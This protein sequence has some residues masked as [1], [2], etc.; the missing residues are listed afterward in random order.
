[1]HKIII[2]LPILFI[3]QFVFGQSQIGHTTITFQDSERG[4]RNIE[5]EIY[6]PAQTA[7]TDTQVEAGQFPV[8]VFGHG[9][10]MSWDAYQNLW[11][12][13]VPRGYIMVFPRTEGS[14]I[15]TDHQ[16][17][18]WDLEFLV[19]QMQVEGAN[20]GSV[21]F[22]AVASETALMGHSM[23]GGAAFLAADSLS[24]NGNQNLKTLIGLAPAES[25]TN[26]VSSINSA[27]SVT[28][29]SIILSGGQD[30]VTPPVDHHIPMYNSLASDC[31]TFINILGGAHCYF[32]NS[33][34][35]CDFGEGTSSTGISITR[36]DQHAVTFDFVNL[37]LDYALKNSCS[38][39]SSFTSLLAMDARITNQQSCSLPSVSILAMGATTFCEGDSV[40]LTSSQNL[41][42]SNGEIGTS[43]Y[44]NQ[45]GSFY[46]FD[47]N[48]CATSN[49][50]LVT[51]NSL[52][53]NSVSQ[54]NESLTA[55]ETGADYQWIDCNTSQNINGETN[56]T[57]NATY[58]SDFAVVVTINSCTDT[59]DCYN[60]TGLSME[61]Q[62]NNITVNIYPNPSKGMVTV[63]AN[64]PTT[65]TLYSVEGKRLQNWK[66]LNGENRLDLQ[67]S[68]G[69]YIW[70]TIGLN[71]ASR[72]GKIVVK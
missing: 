2:G 36:E 13:F 8:I 3:C 10:V 72:N 50:I 26:G 30:G 68:Q 17:F 39:Y 25:S 7:G 33:N 18:G 22:N 32:A 16:Q 62:Y 63:V 44:A 42:W 23:G 9:F 27:L 48:T 41:E 35:N 21:L 51:S 1:M 4:N 71:N 45:S 6:Y 14:I 64:E 60:V 59:S 38:A 61:N 19:E 20:S 52:P 56:I 28:V 43:I 55:I 54:V 53:D 15:S 29:P 46:A 47:N 65:L 49:N 69:I 5:T 24:T 40:E 12:E 34:F 31:K 57:Y 67:L 70:E 58:N 11:E 37:W 66:L